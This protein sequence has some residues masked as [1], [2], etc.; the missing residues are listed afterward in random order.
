MEGPSSGRRIFHANPRRPLM[1][2]ERRCVGEGEGYKRVKM[3]EE[4]EEEK[5]D[6]TA[7][8]HPARLASWLGE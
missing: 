2:V 6:R 4:G 8:A 3:V 7:A 1:V 5:R